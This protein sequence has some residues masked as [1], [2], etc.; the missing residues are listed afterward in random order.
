MTE[1]LSPKPVR[2]AESVSLDRDSALPLY[3]QVKRRLQAIIQTEALPG[4]RF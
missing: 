2:A 4:G 1:S 3:A